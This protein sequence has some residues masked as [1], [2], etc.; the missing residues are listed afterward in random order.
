MEIGS[1]TETYAKWLE[2]KMAEAGLSTRALARRWNPNDPETARRALR[3]YL[4]GMVPI[5]RTRLEIATHL[6]SQESEP[7]ESDDAEGD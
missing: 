5:T 3:R 4:D 6:G 2:R 1:T 7:A